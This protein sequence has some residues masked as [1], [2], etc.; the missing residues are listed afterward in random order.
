MEGRGLQG[1]YWTLSNKTS[2]WQCNNLCGHSCPLL[3]F[4]LPEHVSLKTAILAV[5]LPAKLSFASVTNAP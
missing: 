5:A 4:W 1:R 2:N 3:E